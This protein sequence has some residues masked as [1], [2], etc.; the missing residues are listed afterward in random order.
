MIV[1]ASAAFKFFV[2]TVVAVAEEGL[3]E[4]DFAA[5]ATFGL[6]DELLQELKRA[7]NERKRKIRFIIMV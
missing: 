3:A 4:S 7:K 6:D 2:S 5:E 1:A